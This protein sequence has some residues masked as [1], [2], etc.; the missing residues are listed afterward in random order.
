VRSDQHQDAKDKGSQR[1]HSY[2]EEDDSVTTAHP[3]ILGSW[4][5][6]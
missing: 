4:L 6:R 2:A 3:A 5:R 1:Q